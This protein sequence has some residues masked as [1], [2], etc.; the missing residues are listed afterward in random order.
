MQFGR[1]YHI[2]IITGAGADAETVQIKYPLDAVYCF[3]V[4]LYPVSGE[5]RNDGIGI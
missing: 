3:F 1:R 5:I 2:I 4:L